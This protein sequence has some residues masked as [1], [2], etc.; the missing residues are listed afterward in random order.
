MKSF[1]VLTEAVRFFSL[2]LLHVNYLEVA[3]NVLPLNDELLE[4]PMIWPLSGCRTAPDNQA[5]TACHSFASANTYNVHAMY[6]RLSCWMCLLT[7]TVTDAADPGVVAAG[8]MP[9]TIWIQTRHRHLI[10]R[11]GHFRV[12]RLYDVRAAYRCNILS[13]YR[14]LR[15]VSYHLWVH[16]T[17]PDSGLRGHRTFLT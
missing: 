5:I 4:S 15:E 16:G 6:R 14:V 3:E 1:C 11:S 13:L 2:F 9:C 8:E 7:G 10:R 17:W 12:G